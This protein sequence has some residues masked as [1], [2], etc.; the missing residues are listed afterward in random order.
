[1][2]Y[3]GFIVRRRSPASNVLLM[4]AGELVSSYLY[5]AILA[6][7]RFVQYYGQLLIVPDSVH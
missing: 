3:S 5:R 7:P 1:M 2:E 4:L 6:R